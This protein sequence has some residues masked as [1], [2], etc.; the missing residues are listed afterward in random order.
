MALAAVVGKPDP[1]RTEIVKAFIVLKDG[2]TVT[3]AVGT[4]IQDFVKHAAVSAR[5]SARDRVH[6]RHADDDDRQGH[7]A[8][9]ARTGVRGGGVQWER[10]RSRSALAAAMAARRKVSSRLATA[11]LKVLPPRTAIN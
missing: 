8:Q 6:R 9:A 11:N 5:I 10:T 3:D 4:E 1:V 7:P 2:M